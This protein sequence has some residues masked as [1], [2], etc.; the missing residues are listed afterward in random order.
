MARNPLRLILA[1]TAVLTAA[2][3]C[4]AATDVFEQYISEYADMAVDQ[5]VRYGIPASVT[6]AQGLLESAAGRST[7]AREGNNHF[8]IKCHN[9]WEGETMLRSD[10]APDECFRVYPDASQSFEDH[11]KFLSRKRYSSL[12]GLEMTDYAGWA[13]GL[14]SCG[15]ATDPHY[16]DRLVAII[17]RYALY[18][19]DGSSDSHAAEMSEFIFATLRDSHPV[20]KSRGLYYVIANP[21]D[22]Y[23]SLAREF[24]VDTARLADYN[25]AAPDAAVRPWEEVYLQ[26]KR[27]EAPEAPARVT[28]GEDESLHSIAQRFAIKAEALHRLNPSAKDRPG[29]RLRLR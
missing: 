3:N 17:E 16:A 22:T 23:A 18:R 21:G 25:D 4:L 29:T 24:N 26:P 6:L 28:I 13:A 12:F 14:K 2:A 19:F 20:R 10:D 27:D 5:Q 15:Y 9:D 11:S 7:L 1:A 8:G